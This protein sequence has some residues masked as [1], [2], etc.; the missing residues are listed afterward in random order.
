METIYIPTLCQNIQQLKNIQKKS[1][2]QPSKLP[3]VPTSKSCEYRLIY[4]DKLIQN[5]VD[6]HMPVMKL[7][8]TIEKSSTCTRLKEQERNI[9]NNM[10]DNMM[11]LNYI[12][13]KMYHKI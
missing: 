7:K 2:K 1:I 13:Q 5:N 9:D 8:K 3:Y 12:H 6:I 11:K 4:E 10:C